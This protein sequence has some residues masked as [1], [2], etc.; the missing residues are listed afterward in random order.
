MRRSL[1]VVGGVALAVVLSQFPEYA[2]Q[3][4][5]RL[6]G[7]VDELRAIAAD[8]DTGAQA[9]GMTRGDALGHYE[10][11]GDDFLIGR[12]VAMRRTIDRYEELSATLDKIRG[13][14]GWERA[15][16]LPAFLD[17]EIGGRTLESFVPAVPVTTEGLAW[18]A[19]GFAIGY[20]L[21]SALYRF[22][23]MFFRRRPRLV[24][25]KI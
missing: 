1:A 20:L 2:Q 18:T 3:Y 24:A 6:G 13:A 7:A 21:V 19:A 22:V 16:M 14:S 11:S 15:T 5:Q 25:T 8:F 23:A 9:A 10:T 12:G 17:S 4:T